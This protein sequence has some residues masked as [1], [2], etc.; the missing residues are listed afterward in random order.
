MESYD[1]A[2]GSWTS[3]AALPHGVHGQGVTVLNGTLYAIGGATEA[4]H[5]NSTDAVLGLSLTGESVTAS[6]STSSTAD[7]S[8][9][10]GSAST[11][12][13]AIHERCRRARPLRLPEEPG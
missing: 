13:A 2:A 7:A 6:A 3:G 8:G 4:G 12:S 10:V 1:V 11:G 9:T 5:S